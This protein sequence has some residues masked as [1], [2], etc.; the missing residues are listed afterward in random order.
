MRYILRIFKNDLKGLFTNFFALVVAGGLCILPALYAWFN[1]YANW[2]PY[3]NTGNVPI[4]VV[5]SDEGW[6][7][8]EGKNN[9]KGN[10]VVKQLKQK[11]SIGWVFLDT[12]EKAVNGVKSGKYYAAL[13][14]DN[15]FTYSMYNGVLDNLQNPKITYY[16][17]DKKNAVATKITDSAASSVKNS[18][19]EAYVEVAAE[20]AFS[21]ANDA[22]KTLK[23][24]ESL[25][26][27]VNKIKKV[28]SSLK[29]YDKMITKLVKANEQLS[30]VAGSADS[31]I[32]KSQK[33][34]TE[35]VK[36]L[37]DG[38]TKLTS[39][40]NSF[41][42]YSQNVSSTL[43][44]VSGCLKA[45][46]KELEDAELAEDGKSLSDDV[47]NIQE[48]ASNLHKELGKLHTSVYY[49]IK[50]TNNENLRGVL[51][52][53]SDMKTISKGMSKKVDTSKAAAVTENVVLSTREL[54]DNYASTVKKLQKMYDKQVVP[55]V[56]DLLDNMSQ[57]LNTVQNLLTNLKN[58]T[59]SMQN[60][61]KGTG[62]TLDTLNMSMEELQKAIKEAR[63]KIEVFINKIENSPVEDKLALVVNFFAGDS[64]TFGK[65]LAEPVK[66]KDVLI[67]G[68][69]NYGSGVAPFYTTL[70][71]WVGMTILV[72]L[73]KVHAEPAEM[74]GIKPYQLFFGR[75][76]LLFTL[77]QIQ[78]AIIVA[79]NL[80][81][82]RIQCKEKLA[83]WGAA[84]MAS[85]TFSLLVYSLT[86][87]FGDIGKAA[88]VIIMIIQIA[89]SGGTYPIEALPSFFRGV[90]IF[91]PFPYAI[92]A[93]RE[94]IGGMYENDYYIYI[95]ELS[96]FCMASLVIGL[97]IRIPFIKLNHFI[98]HR[99]EDTEL[100]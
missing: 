34:L 85:F 29:K 75:Y 78:T 44:D 37:K 76:I 10:D 67:Y 38:Q 27:F 14:I 3:A 64:A 25:D 93:M 11:D 99:M 68:I 91:F 19:N 5:N 20:K 16:V 90:Y 71:I 98:E 31:G 40:K 62:K 7:D 22:V 86:I 56:T 4:A 41:K 79:G 57:T 81:V 84:A 72:S 8:S 39:T 48:S 32:K 65:F 80:F 47:S 52:T 1:I 45:I 66:T 70:A 23:E 51:D 13:I 12:E 28:D 89:G 69:E 96:I 94:C 6:V 97:V 73:I 82:F 18:L 87:A 77:S 43:S 9:N 36:K 35:G 2:D 30:I 17:N 46:S 100:L 50:D 21:E 59:K 74:E 58:T 54:L 88:A 60:V 83:F 92:D 49:I 15:G 95:S 42:A 24:K 63:N 26:K 33:K 53:I 55:Q 61:F